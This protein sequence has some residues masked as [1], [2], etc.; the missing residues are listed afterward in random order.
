MKELAFYGKGGIGKSTTVCNL[1]AAFSELEMN[2]LV[3]GCDPKA[4]CTYTLRGGKI[5]PTVLDVMKNK[6]N[7][8]IEDIVYKGYNGVYCVEAGGPKPG[9]GCAGRGVIVAIEL[10]KKLKVFEKLD[11]DI[12]LY[13]VL[14]DVVCGGFSLP[15]RLNLDVYIVT[16][17][18]FMSLY[19]ANNICR[20]I[21]ELKRDNL[22]GL[23]Y[24]VRGKVDNEEIINKFANMINTKV[25]GKIPYSE[26]IYKAELLGKT[27]FEYN[28]DSEIANVY[29]ELA[30]S[31]LNNTYKSQPNPLDLEEINK[32]RVLG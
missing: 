28:P 1:A 24:N 13:D 11:I 14:G 4:D 31:I 22:A 27:V 7:I 5:I 8:E 23:I 10:L 12:V 18:D 32:L 29:R 17:S 2:V 3:V 19:A 6:R 25:V 26:D 30:K 20:G 9:I 21:K 15:L 16:S